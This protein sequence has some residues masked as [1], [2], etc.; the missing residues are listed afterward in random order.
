MSKQL[1]GYIYIA[2]LFNTFSYAKIIFLS[3]CTVFIS[4]EAAS[5]ILHLAKILSLENYNI[6]LYFIVIVIMILYSE[7]S[8]KFFVIL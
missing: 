5:N 7:K 6:I 3:I 4:A 2:N 8:A 1:I